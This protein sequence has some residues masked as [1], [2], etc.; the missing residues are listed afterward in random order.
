[1][2]FINLISYSASNISIKNKQLILDNGFET[3]DYPLEDLN[4]VLIEN[5]NC[6]ISVR[7]LTELARHNVV[8]YFCDEKHLPCAYLLNYNGFYKNLEVYNYQVNISKPTQKQLWKQLVVAKIEN[9]IKVLDL[10]G[11]KH[12]LTQYLGKIKS[13]DADNIEAIVANL[14]FKHLFGNK[15]TRQNECLINASLN[16]AYAIIRGLVA[17]TVVAHGLLTF[18][19]VFHH[20]KLNAFNLVDDLIEPFR[21]LVDLFVYQNILPL[22]Q[23]ELTTEI[24]QQLFGLLNYDMISINQHQ[25]LTNCV[26]ILVNSLVQSLT[27]NVAKLNCPKVFGLELHQY[28]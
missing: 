18:L 20:N 4:S 15:F 7:T 24:K 2:G 21:P 9:Q 17:R 25:T 6:N 13:A 26:E 3:M 11:I 16:Y 22:N 8:T 28:E 5:R 14:Y 12:N 27:D 19:G 10:C 1:M 23:T